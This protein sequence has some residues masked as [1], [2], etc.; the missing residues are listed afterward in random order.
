MSTTKRTTTTKGAGFGEA[1]VTALQLLALDRAL[2]GLVIGADCLTMRAKGDL[3]TMQRK[4]RVM[5]IAIEVEHGLP[6]LGRSD[7]H[8][9]L[10]VLPGHTADAGNSHPD[11]CSPLNLKGSL[12]KAGGLTSG[13]LNAVPLAEA[14][15]FDRCKRLALPARRSPRDR[16]G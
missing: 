13:A 9:M 6:D 5:R 3:V 2:A 14:E 15:P 10:R 11:G 16:P 7:G 1:T 12:N 4:L 8:K